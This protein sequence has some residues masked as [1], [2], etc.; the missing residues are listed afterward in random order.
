MSTTPNASIKITQLADIGANLAN[1]TI[2]PVVGPGPGGILT[3]QSTT[4][5]NMANLIFANGLVANSITAQTVTNAAQ[6]NITTVG[7]LANLT[8]SGNALFLNVNAGNSLQAVYLIGDGGNITGLQGSQVVGPVLESITAVSIPGANVAGAVANAN[9]ALSAASSNVAVTVSQAVQPNI[10]SV[11]TLSN[12][13]VAGTVGFSGNTGMVGNLS[14]TGNTDLNGGDI[15]LDGNV[16]ITVPDYIHMTCPAPQ[17]ST[18]TPVVAKLPI[19]ING[20]VYWISL[21]AS[22]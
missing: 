16:H 19:E 14:T 9:Y 18:G 15:R 22:P 21:T 5:G 20:T 2:F 8:V 6:P 7:T 3:T 12:L 11:G 1:T 13:T 4:L 10:T 17:A